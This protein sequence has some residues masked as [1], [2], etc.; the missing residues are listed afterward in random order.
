MM[1]SGLGVVNAFSAYNG[2]IRL[3]NLLYYNLL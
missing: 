1:L 2:F 3:G